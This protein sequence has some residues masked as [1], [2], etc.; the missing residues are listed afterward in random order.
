MSSLIIKS[1]N[2]TIQGILNIWRHKGIQED[3]ETYTEDKVG[4]TND[5]TE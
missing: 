1:H 2:R 4:F 3:T 5:K